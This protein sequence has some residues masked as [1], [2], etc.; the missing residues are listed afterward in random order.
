MTTR[1][2]KNPKELLDFLFA[3]PGGFGVKP[4]KPGVNSFDPTLPH[5]LR[6]ILTGSG[7]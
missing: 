5:S 2:I 3:D 4:V 6:P 1:T 7:K